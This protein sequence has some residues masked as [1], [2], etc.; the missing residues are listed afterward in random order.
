MAIECL[1]YH[2]KLV[3]LIDFDGNENELKLMRFLLKDGHILEKMNIIWLKGV[4]DTKEIIQ[5]MMEF[6]RSSSN[7]A[8]TFLEPKSVIDIFNL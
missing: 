2:L 4:E 8:F 3:E 1:T 7:V 5:E 6:Q